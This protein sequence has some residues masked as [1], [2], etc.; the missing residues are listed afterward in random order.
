MKI[1]RYPDRK[2][3]T[4]ITTRP[5]TDLSQLNDTVGRILADV[6]RDGDEAVK[7]YEEKFDRARLSS[8]QASEKET[9]EAE[10]SLDPALKEALRQAHANISRFHEAQRQE[11]RKVETCKGVVCWQKSVPIERAG[12]YVPGG[13]APLFST[14]LMLA[15]PAKIAGCKEII[16]CTPP[17]AD[18]HIHPA[19][20]VAARIAGVG[21]IFKAG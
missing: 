13:T 12:L 21:K 5:E 14:V 10:A 19:I 15:T 18:G 20:L 6:R 16:M 2:Q 9:D 4:E 8:L 7:A 17:D 1:Y 11:T 3:W